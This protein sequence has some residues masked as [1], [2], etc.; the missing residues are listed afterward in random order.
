MEAR[1]PKKP[2]P[3]IVAPSAPIGTSKIAVQ[4]SSA[5][6]VA[7]PQKKAR[8]ADGDLNELSVVNT[9][10]DIEDEEDKRGRDADRRAVVVEEILDYGADMLRAGARLRAKIQAATARLFGFG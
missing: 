1:A 7:Q 4:P 2:V 5:N 8:R 3:Q 10:V 9:I 6:A